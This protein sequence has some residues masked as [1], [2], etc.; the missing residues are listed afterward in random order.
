[1]QA[2]LGR[3]RVLLLLRAHLPLGADAR[4]VP[5][6][7]ER[8]GVV[9]HAAL[10]VCVRARARGAECAERLG[11][12]AP[13]TAA[14]SGRPFFGLLSFPA[15]CLVFWPT[16]TPSRCPSGCGCCAGITLYYRIITTTSKALVRNNSLPP[17]RHTHAH[18]RTRTAHT[19]THMLVHTR[20][21]FSFL[22]C[23][24]SGCRL[25]RLRLVLY[26]P[27]KVWLIGV[28]LRH[29]LVGD[30]RQARAPP[31]QLVGQLVGL[32]E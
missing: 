26:T 19:L 6:S 5:L 31:K 7:A 13:A 4:R 8:V 22:P 14:S 10:C 32:H 21:R 18:T 23:S 20:Y 9:Q 29:A 25:S 15:G 11:G 17:K 24:F 16:A 1:M 30:T 27:P 2:A 3:G 28:A 12:S